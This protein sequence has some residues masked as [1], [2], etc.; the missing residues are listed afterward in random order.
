MVVGK[1]KMFTMKKTE[2]CTLR[3][4]CKDL[5]S[6]IGFIRTEDRLKNFQ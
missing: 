3:L 2:H 4:I 6:Y 5:H 1:G